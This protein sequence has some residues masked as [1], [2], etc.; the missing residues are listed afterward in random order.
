M[1]RFNYAP[2]RFE[3]AFG[4]ASSRRAP[5]ARGPLLALAASL[6]LVGTLVFVQAFRL[7]AL[8]GAAA[9]LSTRRAALQPA[10]VRLRSAEAEE[11]R[12]EGLLAADR[13]VRRSGTLSANEIAAIGNALPAQT[14]LTGVRIE[15]GAVALEGR[16][17]G[18]RGV[19]DALA[20][21]ARVDG[22]ATVRLITA[23]RDAT[24][25]DVAYEIALERR[26]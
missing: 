9:V 5:I 22:I 24:R 12:L 18:M 14:W 3:R 1:T 11:R 25:S 6:L 15:P 13:G 23:K 20:A 17:A 16:C 7:R 10:L 26:P 21:L 19:A 4:A 2:S 8:E